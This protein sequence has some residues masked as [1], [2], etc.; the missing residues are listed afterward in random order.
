MCSAPSPPGAP[1]FRNKRRNLYCSDQG[2]NPDPKGNLRT[3][4][5]P[6]HLFIEVHLL[7]ATQKEPHLPCWC[8]SHGSRPICIH[9][10]EQQ[11]GQFWVIVAA[12]TAGTSTSL[13]APGGFSGAA[14][15]LNSPPPPCLLDNTEPSL[16]SRHHKLSAVSLGEASLCSR[17]LLP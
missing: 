7:G 8:G 12:P 6:L 3:P 14:V 17:C 16:N 5:N 15:H 9:S 1:P 11:L 13:C 10:S 2:Q 4:P